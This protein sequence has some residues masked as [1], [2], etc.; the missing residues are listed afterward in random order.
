MGNYNMLRSI[1][2]EKKNKIQEDVKQIIFS[3]LYGCSPVC[4]RKCRVKFAERGNT[5]V[6]NLHVYRSLLFFCSNAT[7]EV[8]CCD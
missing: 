8:G 5:F 7:P 3:T 1:C 2:R 4:V 6:Q